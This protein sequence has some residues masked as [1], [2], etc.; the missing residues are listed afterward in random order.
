MTLSQ[1]WLCSDSGQLLHNS[2]LKADLVSSAGS[3]GIACPPNISSER[4]RDPSQRKWEGDRHK[5]RNHLR[6]HRGWWKEPKHRHG[7]DLVRGLV[8]SS[9][10]QAFTQGTVLACSKEEMKCLKAFQEYQN[11]FST[12]IKRERATTGKT[13]A[14]LAQSYC[15]ISFCFLS[16]LGMH[17]RN[18]NLWRRQKNHL[19]T[20]SSTGLLR[21]NKK[22]WKFKA[23]F[24]N[25]R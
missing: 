9:P 14:L 1:N 25:T 23:G 8:L 18:I 3:Q 7:F 17:S 21:N 22:K 24:C 16:T 6:H 5:K 10:K 19:N 12:N 15:W 13:F 2:M 11:K 4:K 20:S